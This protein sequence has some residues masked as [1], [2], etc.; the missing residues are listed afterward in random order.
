MSMAHGL[1][2]RVPLLDHSIVELAVQE[3]VELLAVAVCSNHVHLVVGPLGKPVEEFVAVCKTAGRRAL[4]LAGLA[5]KVWT[6][7]YDRRF[8]F[9]EKS[10]R[11]RIEYVNKHNLK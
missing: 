9:D 6:R 10:M 1:E 3:G 11:E 8:C 4:H 7:G 5:G 2:S